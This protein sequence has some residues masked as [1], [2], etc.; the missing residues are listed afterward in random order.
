MRRQTVTGVTT[1]NLPTANLIDDLIGNAGGNTVR[2]PPERLAAM[3][4][5]FQ[6]PSHATLAQLTADRSWPAGTLAAVWNDG[7]ANGVYRKSGNPGAGNWSRIGDLPM[8]SF[9]ADLLAQKAD[10][11]AL[12]AEATA[13]TNATRDTGLL[14]LADVAGTPN[15]ITAVIAPALPGI[16]LS[17]LSTVV[18]VP[19]ADNTGPVT[20]NVGGGGNWP[21]QR[22][23][24]APVQGGDLRAGVARHYRRVGNAWRMVGEAASQAQ[25]RIDAQTGPLAS[26]TTQ[27]EADIAQLRTRS[28]QA[29]MQ[30][31]PGAYPARPEGAL[32]VHWWGWESPGARMKAT[33]VWVM[34]EE[35]QPPEAPSDADLFETLTI[36]PGWGVTSFVL[37]PVPVMVPELSAVQI[38]IDAGGWRDMELSPTPAG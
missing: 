19:V 1:P 12:A 5:T 27:A 2:I 17:G 34:T 18:L 28:I 22:G 21:V 10:A 9:G 37:D 4:Q 24:G 26:R 36:T 20:L 7:A 15:D 8:S 35:P 6:G 32:S 30:T 11:N 33:D 16:T 29:V 14:P 23:D 25:V 38:R 31:G 3:L 13:R